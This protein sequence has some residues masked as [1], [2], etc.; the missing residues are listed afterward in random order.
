MK[1]YENRESGEKKYF[2]AEILKLQL[3]MELKKKT[4]QI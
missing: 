4:K 2:S 1:R 3:Q